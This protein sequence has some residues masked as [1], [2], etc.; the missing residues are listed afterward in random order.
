MSKFYEAIGKL[1]TPRQDKVVYVVRWLTALCVSFNCKAPDPN[2]GG[3]KNQE[4]ISQLAPLPISFLPKRHH[5]L[6]K[7][8]EVV[9]IV[10]SVYK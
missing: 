2:L 9:E 6:S 10:K 5:Y 3:L 1:C 4:M 7:N 8:C